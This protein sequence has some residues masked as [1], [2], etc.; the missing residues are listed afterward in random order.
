MSGTKVVRVLTK[1]EVMVLCQRKIDVLQ[2]EIKEWRK[3]AIRHEALSI[4]DEKQ[5]EARYS[6]I[7]DMF[8]TEKFK[9]V[10][11][12]C[13]AEIVS[14]RQDMER[15]RKQS[16][17]KAEE[18]RSIRRRLQYSAETLIQSFTISGVAIPEELQRIASSVL[19]ASSSELSATTSVLNR[20]AM[21]YTSNIIDNQ[22][23]TP[24]QKE[25]SKN[26]SDGKKIQT[27]AEWKLNQEGK[28]IC[29]KDRR[30]D[31]LLAEIEALESQEIANSFRDRSSIITSEPSSSRRSLLTDSLILD[32]IAHSNAQKE[33]ENTLSPLREIRSELRSL[34]LKTAREL[35]ALLTEAIDTQNISN[36]DFLKKKSLELI[37]KEEQAMASISRREAILKGLTALGYEVQE[38]MMTAW[39]K[40]GRIIVQKP[41]EKTYGIELAAASGIERVQM[42]L[43]TFEQSDEISKAS[44]DRDREASWC[45][46]FSDLKSFIE[47]SGTTFEIEKALPAGTKTVKIV[48]KTTCNNT[49]DSTQFQYPLIKQNKSD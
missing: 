12:H 46:E 34:S 30:L 9:D 47:Q 1:Q 10:T 42:Q 14:L 43:V 3:C 23:L 6:A 4:V 21:E 27:L 45:N 32:L 26:L 8:E 33:I 38:N 29:E 24:L 17:A 41:H 16:I 39:V 28:S 37:K 40:N 11:K 13:N 20:I 5:I 35:V 48:T 44:E 25:L 19:T 2:D 31:K 49:S 36:S 18:Q 15:I 22:E 7:L